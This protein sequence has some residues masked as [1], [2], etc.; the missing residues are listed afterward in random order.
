MAELDI[1]ALCVEA[2]EI[3]NAIEVI[4]T[5]RSAIAIHTALGMVIGAG[6]TE[7]TRPDLEDTMLRIARVALGEFE[8]RRLAKL[9]G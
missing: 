2:A 8:R 9:N 7:L 1:R 4:I 3:A 6:E 5:G